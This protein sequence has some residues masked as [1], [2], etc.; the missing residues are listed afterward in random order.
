MLRLPLLALPHT[1]ALVINKGHYELLI[2]VAVAIAIAVMAKK[3]EHVMEI[4]S[5]LQLE[6]TYT[7]SI[8][9]FFL[10]DDP[11]LSWWIAAKDM[12]GMD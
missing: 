2:F 12:T 11:P 1:I 9:E 4:L 3:V 7:D 6:N 8:M 10:L 5:Y